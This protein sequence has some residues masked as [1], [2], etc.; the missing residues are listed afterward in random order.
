MES[1]VSGTTP[2]PAAGGNRSMMP[3]VV[4]VGLLVAVLA[5]IALWPGDEPRGRAGRDDSAQGRGA[6]GRSG[7]V[8]A[9]GE[10]R[11]GVKPRAYDEPSAPGGSG[12]RNPA[13]K[14]PPVG[15]SP[16]MPSNDDTPP[17]FESK[18]AEIAWYEAKLASAQKNLE[19]RKKFVD[20]LP[21]V[22]ERLEKGPEP[23]KQLEAF[24]GRSKIVTANYDR[25]IAK[26][27]ELEKK[28]S[29]LRGS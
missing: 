1:N 6:E 28:I 23:D 16:D 17:V 24:E 5:I 13:V 20:R 25:A 14:L 18:Q 19:S 15:M 10:D 3:V 4:G 2:P 12:K 22:R 7:A 11:G 29:E 9:A 27:S 26:V 21:A 8:A